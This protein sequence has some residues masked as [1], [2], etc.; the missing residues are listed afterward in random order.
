MAFGVYVGRVRIAFKEWAIVVDFLGRG[1]QI[2][3]LRKGGIAEGRGGFRIDHQEFLLLPTHFHQERESITEAA[4]AR[5][6]ELGP[7]RPPADVV[8]IEFLARVAA[9]RQLTCL[10]AAEALRGQHCWTDVTIAS[11]FAWGQARDIHALA[12]RVFRLPLPIELPRLPSYGGCRSWVELE[13]DLAT[14]GSVPVLDAVAFDQK[15]NR[16]FAALNPAANA[17]LRTGADPV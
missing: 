6:D 1:E 17:S 4:R 15:L 16:F 8:R 14:A 2:L 13:T 12:L 5:Y 7:T 3:V 9:T 11:R 10:S